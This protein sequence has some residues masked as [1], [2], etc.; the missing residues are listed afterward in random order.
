MIKN[1][2]EINELRNMYARALYRAVKDTRAYKYLLF[3]QASGLQNNGCDIEE[4]DVE[5]WML[6]KKV[7]EMIDMWIRLSQAKKSS[8]QINLSEDEMQK[9]NEYSIPSGNIAVLINFSGKVALSESLA[10]AGLC[11]SETEYYFDLEKVATIK[12][13]VDE[14]FK[15]KAEIKNDVS[16]YVGKLMDAVSA[17]TLNTA[18]KT[19]N[20]Y[21]PFN[22]EKVAKKH[23]SLHDFASFKDGKFVYSAD[24]LTAPKYSDEAV[25]ILNIN[26]PFK[27]SISEITEDMKVITDKRAIDWIGQSFTKGDNN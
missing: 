4:N 23:A 12:A 25:S 22:V 11:L 5:W 14:K 27:A 20:G 3:N 15:K 24:C 21:V 6:T 17:E 9:V 2:I 16:D 7:R 8:T 19:V 18:Y 26:S 13:T 10:E 1:K